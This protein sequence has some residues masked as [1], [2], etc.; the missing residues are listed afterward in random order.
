MSLSSLHFYATLVA[1]LWVS[2][3]SIT[4][5]QQRW[6]EIIK[7]LNKV[8]DD[9]WSTD[10]ENT[11]QSSSILNKTC[12]SLVVALLELEEFYQ[13]FYSV[14]LGRWVLISVKLSELRASSVIAFLFRMTNGITKC[15]DS[16]RQVLHR[17]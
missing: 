6:P 10:N 13:D 12:F 15:A 5:A 8:I 14:S 9:N 7:I 17:Y 11:D 1:V 3:T 16:H 4:T 2:G